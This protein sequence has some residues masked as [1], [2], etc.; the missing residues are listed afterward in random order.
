MA[1]RE[2]VPLQGKPLVLVVEDNADN[3]RLINDL[4]EVYNIHVIQAVN[5][6]AALTALQKQKPDL[7]LMDISLQGTDGLTFTRMLKGDPGTRDIPIVALTAHA[8]KQDRDN[9]YKAGCDGFIAKPIDTRAL[10]ELIHKFL[11]RD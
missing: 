9:A 3:M 4:L 8:M 10:P 6:A 1:S 2:A 11:R 5:P 7:I